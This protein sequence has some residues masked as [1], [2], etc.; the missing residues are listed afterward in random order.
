MHQVA[1]GQRR[2]FGIKAHVGV[3]SDARLIHTELVSAINEAAREA[4]PF[5]LHGPEARV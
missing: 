3:D 4:L 5:L 1:R 2:N